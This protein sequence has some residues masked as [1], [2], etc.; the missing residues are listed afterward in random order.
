MGAGANHFYY[1]VFL[2]ANI[3]IQSFVLNVP[4]DTALHHGG[5]IVVFNEAFPSGLGH[6][7]LATS[8]ILLEALLT[9]VLNRIV[10]CISQ[11][12]IDV[13]LDSMVLKFVHQ[14]CP[15][16]FYL[17]C[18]CNGQEDYLCEF[19]VREGS[20]NA[21]AQD[22]GLLALYLLHDDH[23]FVNAVHHQSHDVRPRH[24]GQLLSNNVLEVHQVPH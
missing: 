20:E 12:I 13:S 10:V 4:V 22:D 9:E 5:T 19:L 14:A 18:R 3:L 2:S 16:A 17:L 6:E 24:A 23:G 21:P 15:V 11:E 7:A 8:R 1:L